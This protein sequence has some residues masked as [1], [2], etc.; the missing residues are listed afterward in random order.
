MNDIYKRL[1]KNKLFKGIELDKLEKLISSKLSVKIFSSN[2]LLINEGDSCDFIAFVLEGKVFIQKL[3]VSGSILTIN[4]LSKNSLFGGAILFSE[5]NY[6]PYSVMSA[7]P[8]K[9]LFIKKTAISDLLKKD[10]AFTKN[11]IEFL[12]NRINVFN[13]KI[14]LL[15]VRD[16]RSKLILYLSSETQKNNNTSFILSHTREEI[17]NIIGVA[18]P[19]VSRELKNMVDDQLIKIDKRKIT[20][21]NLDLLKLPLL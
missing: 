19:S 20:I 4:T 12:S 3:F 11:Y 13:N 10:Y 21:I 1:H 8:C 9:I 17:A 5:N 6:F 16:V 2:F 7:T 14:N 15:K 18:R